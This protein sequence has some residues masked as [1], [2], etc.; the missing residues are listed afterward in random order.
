MITAFVVFS[1]LIAG[2][3]FNPTTGGKAVGET[4]QIED[5]SNCDEEKD[6][7]EPDCQYLRMD[8]KVLAYMYYQG[9]MDLCTEWNRYE[10]FVNQDYDNDQKIDRVYR[11]CKYISGL[12]YYNV[13]RIEF[14]NGERLVIDDVG[15]GTPSIF[16]ED[17]D[18][19]GINEI[20]VKFTYS[21]VSTDPSSV[22]EMAV[23]RLGVSGFEKVSWPTALIWTNE[24]SLMDSTPKL[25]LH[26]RKIDDTQYE[27][28]SKELM[29]LPTAQNA[30]KKIVTVD[31]DT[32]KN[33]YK[34][35]DD[36]DKSCTMYQLDL[37]KDSNGEK[38]LIGYFNGFDRWTNFPI[39]ITFTL[40]NGQLQIKKVTTDQE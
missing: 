5:N 19:D 10:S 11:S 32:A 12:N 26:Y 33:Y 39:K 2:C 14:G 28:T 7:S 21:L 31:A 3:V 38:E 24:G 18:G 4:K 1:M 37:T 23:Y 13:Y 35:I 20:V 30:V 27:V 25:S 34:N 16:G 29:T 6:D 40:E 15:T 36:S 22:G 9:Y 17:L 8:T